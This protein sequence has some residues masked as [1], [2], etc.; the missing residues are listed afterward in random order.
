MRFGARASS[1]D[2][3]F[4]FVDHVHTFKIREGPPAVMRAALFSDCLSCIYFS[5]DQRHATKKDCVINR[6][7][8][9]DAEPVDTLCDVL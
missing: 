6:L 1:Q 4:G 7:M 8:T 5:Y 3:A 2:S 9:H